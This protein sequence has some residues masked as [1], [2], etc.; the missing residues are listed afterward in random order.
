MTVHNPKKAGGDKSFEEDLYHRS[1][2]NVSD[3]DEHADS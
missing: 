2:V 1:T 3:S